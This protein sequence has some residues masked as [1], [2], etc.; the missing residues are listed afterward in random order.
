M[1]L[2]KWKNYLI[3]DKKRNFYSAAVLSLSCLMFIFINA[4]LI[5]ND[6]FQYTDDG[7]VVQK[8]W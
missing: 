6:V 1:S 8:S 7:C 3:L 4:F 5:F 2:E